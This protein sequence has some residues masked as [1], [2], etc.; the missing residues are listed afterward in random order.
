MKIAVGELMQAQ[1]IL[2]ELAMAKIPFRAS[3][4][5]SRLLR[6]TYDDVS[7]FSE[8]HN[9]LV[10]KYGHEVKPA[11]SGNYQ[12]DTDKLEDFQKELTEL[13]KIEVEI[14]YIPLTIESMGEISVEPSKLLNAMWL[15]EDSAKANA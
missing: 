11:G 8:K 12:V 4:H 6:K 14:D 13:N 5:L 9:I 3:Y 10:K 1:P 15:F 7:V 2:A